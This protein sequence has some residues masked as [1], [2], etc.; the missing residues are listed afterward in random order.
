VVESIFITDKFFH[1]EDG[2]TA[3]NWNVGTS[4]SARF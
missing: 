3:L 1:P 4:T 2:G